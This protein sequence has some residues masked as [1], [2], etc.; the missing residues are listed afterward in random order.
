MGRV[1]R[2]WLIVHDQHRLATGGLDVPCLD[3]PRA[4]P[5]KNEDRG[6]VQPALWFPRATPTQISQNADDGSM[7]SKFAEKCSATD[8][9]AKERCFRVQ[10]RGHGRQMTPV[11]LDYTSIQDTSQPNFQPHVRPSGYLSLEREICKRLAHRQRRTRV[12]RL[13]SA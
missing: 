13:S 10:E 3:G 11:T 4:V 2:A 12:R 1:P 7:R 5:A 8:G 9:S 6:P